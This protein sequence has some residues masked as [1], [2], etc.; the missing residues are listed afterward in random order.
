[1][2]SVSGTN[3]ER[4]TKGADDEKGRNKRED[5][6]DVK[7]AFTDEGDVGTYV[8]PS[9]PISFDELDKTPPLPSFTLP[10]TLTRF[11]ITNR[12]IPGLLIPLCL[13]LFVSGIFDFP[14]DPPYGSSLSGVLFRGLHLFSVSTRPSPP[15]PFPPPPCVLPRPVTPTFVYLS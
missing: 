10:T 2:G 12:F 4:G 7:V 11:H 14:F 1:M 13:P 3:N 15:R 6:V 8:V 5:E 9:V